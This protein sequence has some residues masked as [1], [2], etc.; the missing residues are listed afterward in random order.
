VPETCSCGTQLVENALFCHRCGKAQ[1]ELISTAADEPVEPAQAPVPP[2]PVIVLPPVGFSNGIAVRICFMVASVASILDAMPLLQLFCVI[3]SITA[4][5]VS[6]VLYR[7]ATGLALTVREGVKLGMVTGV[8]NSLILTVLTTISVASN[9]AELGALF[10]DQVRLKAASDPA[11]LAMVDNPYF[12]AS[13][14][15]FLLVMIF[16]FVTATCIVGGALG[17]RILREDR[18]PGHQPR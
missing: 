5:F 11:T 17:A 6:V 10:R 7:R 9:S 16:V 13:A 1:R 15:L 14:I 8:L 12:L 2:P 4:G 18:A 3:W